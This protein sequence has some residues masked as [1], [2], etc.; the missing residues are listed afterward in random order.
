MKIHKN[1]STFVRVREFFKKIFQ[2]VGAALYVQYL[3]KYEFVIVFQM[4]KHDMKRKKIG[5]GPNDLG[6]NHCFTSSL[7]TLKPI[8]V[9]DIS[10]LILKIRK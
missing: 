4:R 6:L 9:S 8:T 7:V 3:F 5:W 1:N 10:C 2:N